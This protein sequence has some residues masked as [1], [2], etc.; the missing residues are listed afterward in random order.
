MQKNILWLLLAF[1]CLTIVFGV[2]NHEPWADEAQAWLLV[3]DNSIPNLLQAL[4]SEGHPPLWYLLIFPLAK[5]GFPYISINILSA[6]CM[7]VAT[8]IYMFKTKL[9]V[10]LR[11]S[12]PFSY[13]FLFEYAVFGRSYSLI[14]LLIALIVWLYPDRMK[15]PIS[16]SAC[17]ACL[18]NTHVLLFSFSTGLAILFV[19]DVF[20]EKLFSRTVVAGVCIMLIGGL[21]LIPYLAFSPLVKFFESDTTDH[22]SPIKKTIIG[23]TLVADYSVLNY[24]CLIFIGLVLLRNVRGFFLFAMGI[25]GLLYIL[26]YRYSFSAIWHYGLLFVVIV[27]ACSISYFYPSDFKLADRFEKIAVWGVPLLVLLQLPSTFKTLKLDSDYQYSGAKEAAEYLNDNKQDSAIIVGWGPTN[28]VL[29]Y[30][31]R[32]VKI[33]SAECERYATYYIYDSCFMKKI[34]YY[35]VDY[36]VKIAHDHFS[37][38]LS[39]ITFLLNYPVQERTAKF[40]DLVYS[41]SPA[42]QAN[43]TFYIYKFKNGVK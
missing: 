33:Y 36:A 40:L 3:R 29:P 17:V 2:F 37:D 42:I 9:P 5:L 14:F 27:A 10:A 31:A 43:E 30:M 19:Y 23:G 34:W 1:Y 7:V 35:P 38:R 41:T 25:S 26:A 20:R 6:G 28:A 13:F 11:I 16:F 15:K 18:F 21:Y 24:A 22:I 8:Y 4:P 32:N 39:K 12:V